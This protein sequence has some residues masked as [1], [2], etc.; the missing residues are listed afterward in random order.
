MCAAEGLT[1][2]HVPPRCFFP[3]P[4]PKNMVTVPSCQMH[5]NDISKDVE[6]VRN[7]IAGS[8]GINDVGLEM[9]VVNQM[10]FELMR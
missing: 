2:E 10:K 9:V 4:Y 3:K 6:Y 5:N 8:E 1:R 7:I